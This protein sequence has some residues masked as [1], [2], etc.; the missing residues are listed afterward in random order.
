MVFAW[1]PVANRWPRSAGLL[2]WWGTYQCRT[3]EK[4]SNPQSRRDLS[5]SLHWCQTSTTFRLCSTVGLEYEQ[6]V[7]IKVKIQHFLSIFWICS[8]ESLPPFNRWTSRRNLRVNEGCVGRQ[9][10]RGS[11]VEP[12]IYIT[13]PSTQCI[14]PHSLIA[15][16]LSRNSP[17]KIHG[18]RRYKAWHSRISANESLQ[19]A[20]SQLHFWHA[21]E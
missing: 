18:H 14:T 15:H 13:K 10:R 2:Y 9:L 17:G 16:I 7:R 21:N 8:H 5:W 3:L 11:L 1:E 6:G 19:Y 12:W 20:S 4:H